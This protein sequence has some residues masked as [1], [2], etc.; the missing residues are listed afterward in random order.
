MLDGAK[1]HNFFDSEWDY[2]FGAGFRSLHNAAALLRDYHPSI[3]LPSHGPV[4][5]QPETQL[6]AYL[7]KLFNLER[8]LIR[9]YD[10]LTYASASQ[11][12]VSTPSKVPY[13]WQISPHL[14]KFKGPE[15][16]P[17]LSL[18]LS[19]NGNALLVDCGLFDTTFLG[20]SLESMRDHYGLKQIDA[21]IITHIHGDHFLEAPYIKRKW[22]TPVWALENMVPLMEHPERYD[23]AALLPAYKNGY[24][25]V[26]VDRVFKPG[27]TFSWEGYKFTI[28]W[29]PGQTEF[30][31]CMH[32]VIDGM[33]VAFTGDNIF[34][35]PGNPIHTG[36]EALVARNSAVLEEGDSV[37]GEYLTQ[38]KPDI[39]VG[40][41][42]Y[43]MDKPAKIIDR[44]R[45][46]AYKMRNALQTVSSDKDYR[47]WFDPY[48]VRS[49][50]YRSEMKK[51]E[52]VEI[53]V[54]VR[55]FSEYERTYRIEI[56]TPSGLIANPKYIE[57][58]IKGNSRAAIPVALTSL[59]DATAGNSIVAFDVTLDGKQYGELFDAIVKIKN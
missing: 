51:G 56:H 53:D 55:N 33:V 42:S 23:L 32:G 28:D 44:Y 24:D 14:F 21:L 39:L 25:S 16:S 34:G 41:H 6:N 19:G 49:D 47:Y 2:G 18:I 43:V 45:E 27:E 57:K 10:V 58:K 4:I 8:L 7:S 46:W 50:P 15:Y 11:D 22:G 36:H 35:D 48:W 37:A 13:L 30:A 59:P 31:L 12:K 1:M 29:M 5:L 3:L 26:H 54:E 20:R 40:G 52:M 17:N 9:G 38:L